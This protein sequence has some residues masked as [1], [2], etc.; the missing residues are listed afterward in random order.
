MSLIRDG[1]HLLSVRRRAGDTF[2]DIFVRGVPSHSSSFCLR[3]ATREFLQKVDDLDADVRALI[4]LQA[5]GDIRRDAIDAIREEVLAGG[6]VVSW[7]I[8]TH[9]ASLTDE[10]NPVSDLSLVSALLV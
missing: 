10:F 4:D 9:S 3:L 1:A 8:C 2:Q 6:A 7:H 5:E